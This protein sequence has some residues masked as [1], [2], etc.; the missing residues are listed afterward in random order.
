MFKNAKPIWLQGR[1]REKNVFAAF[2]LRATPPLQG[3]ITLHVTGA[4]FYRVY[5]NGTFLGFGPARTALGYAREDVFTLARTDFGELN[6]VIEVCGYYCRSLST[7]LQPSFLMAE[8]QCGE[9]AIAWT[10]E[11]TAAFAPDCK[12]QRVERYSK[13]RTKAVDIK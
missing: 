12:L 11:K 10:D 3:K 9:T 2:Q 6:I 7:V 8:L 5:V 1:S 13:Q 4:T